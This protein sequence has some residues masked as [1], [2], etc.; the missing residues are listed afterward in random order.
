VATKS[1]RRSSRL[2]AAT[3]ANATYE[4]RPVFVFNRDHLW[5]VRGPKRDQASYDL[6][7]YLGR[8]TF[9]K[10]YDP[11]F[12]MGVHNDI[13]DNQMKEL[14]WLERF[15]V[16]SASLALDAN[17]L[18]YDPRDHCDFAYIDE[19]WR[20]IQDR[21]NSGD[22]SDLGCA[23][24]TVA[25]FYAH[26]LY[27][28]VV[29]AASGVLPLYDPTHPVGPGTTQ[30]AVFDR[31][32][33]DINNKKPALMEAQTR[34][35]W[36]GKLISGQRW[37]W[38]TTYPDDI[39]AKAELASRRCLPDHDLLAVDAKSTKDNP[40]HL[41]PTKTVYNQQFDLRKS[42]AERHVRALFLDWHAKHHS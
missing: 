8:R 28:Q 20:R 38:Y 21:L 10:N 42:A 31:T 15:T 23:C 11:A 7:T 36:Q 13:F 40:K 30:D 37:S 5:R 16:K 19:S 3:A 6:D 4:Y 24:H 26:T 22:V 2:P 17:V 25:D 12:A 1:S 32:R 9:W 34:V 18:S 27:A 35:C 39:Q 14:S 33:F 41:Y 29:P